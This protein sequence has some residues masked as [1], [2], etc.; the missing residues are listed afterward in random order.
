[1]PGEDKPTRI[2]GGTQEGPGD[3]AVTQSP[4]HETQERE[5]IGT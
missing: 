2:P 5:P 4:E 3:P 1:V